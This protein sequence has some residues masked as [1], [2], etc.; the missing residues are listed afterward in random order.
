MMSCSIRRNGDGTF[1]SSG[2]P[3]LAK[4]TLVLNLIRQDL[5]AGED[6]RVLRAADALNG[7]I[8]FYAQK[9][10]FRLCAVKINLAGGSPLRR[11]S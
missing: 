3:A 8:V 6:F 7:A 4:A 5:A 9:I 11:P 1:T 2:R 10:S